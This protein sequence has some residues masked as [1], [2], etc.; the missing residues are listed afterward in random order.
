MTRQ[1]QIVLTVLVFNFQDYRNK[2]ITYENNSICSVVENEYSK[3]YVTSK[4][5]IHFND[6]FKPIYQ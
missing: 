3:S 1:N 6:F 4:Y 2:I 5:I